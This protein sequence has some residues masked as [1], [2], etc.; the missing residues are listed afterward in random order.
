VETPEFAE[1]MQGGIY[2]ARAVLRKAKGQPELP[3]LV[4]NAHTGSIPIMPNPLLQG[5]ARFQKYSLRH[6]RGLSATVCTDTTDLNWSKS[7]STDCQRTLS[8]FVSIA[9]ERSE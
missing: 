5:C 1:P 3:P 9:I 2:A 6:S 7:V 4:S 8:F